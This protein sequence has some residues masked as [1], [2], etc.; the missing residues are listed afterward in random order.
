MRFRLPFVG[1]KAHDA[2]VAGLLMQVADYVGKLALASIERR[3]LEDE[4]S[5]LRVHFEDTVKAKD[6]AYLRL[7]AAKDGLILRASE[8][9]SR[10]DSLGIRTPYDW[11]SPAP[12]W[13]STIAT[14]DI[15]G[16]RGELGGLGGDPN[17][18]DPRYNTS[19]P[20]AM[21]LPCETSLPSKRNG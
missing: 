15:H 9:E 13:L 4:L 16:V 14:A 2:K 5:R 19:L 18:D 1:R 17:G 7:M 6:E 21:G 11:A 20:M 8:A 10:F 3:Q 12:C